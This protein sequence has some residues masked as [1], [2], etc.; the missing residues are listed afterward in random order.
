MDGLKSDNSKLES[1]IFSALELD[2]S[3]LI[4]CVQELDNSRWGALELNYSNKN[5]YELDLSLEY[6]VKD[7]R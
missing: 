3:K 6:K 4:T 1:S 7:L 5:I 2:H